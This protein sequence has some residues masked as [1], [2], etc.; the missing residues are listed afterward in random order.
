MVV[1]ISFHLAV[2]SV[3]STQDGFNIFQHLNV[4]KPPFCA[5]FFLCARHLSRQLHTEQHGTQ[6]DVIGSNFSQVM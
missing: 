4:S 2:L 1:Q 5:E 3:G 6:L